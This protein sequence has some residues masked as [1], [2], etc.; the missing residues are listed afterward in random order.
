MGKKRRRATE[1]PVSILDPV[2]AEPTAP[3]SEPERS[4]HR[5]PASLMDTIPD[6][7]TSPRQLA[8]LL[9]SILA[10]PT[11][12]SLFVKYVVLPLLAP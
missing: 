9:G 10:F 8:L 6:P 4:G 1:N 3:R 7:V 2:S 12:V 5:A 11:V